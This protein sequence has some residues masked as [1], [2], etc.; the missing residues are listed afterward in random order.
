MRVPVHF[1]YL[2]F[3]SQSA[4]YAHWFVFTTQDI[5]D[6]FVFIRDGKNEVYYSQ[7]ISYNQRS[8][9]IPVEGALIRAIQDGGLEICAQAKNSHEISRKWY[10]NQCKTVPSD[11]ARW[12]K[13]LNLDKR[14][15]NKKTRKYKSN[16]VLGLVS[17]SILI[18]LCIFLGVCL[19]RLSEFE[20]WFIII[21][22]IFM[23]T[24][25]FTL[26]CLAVTHPIDDRADLTVLVYER[27]VYE[28]FP[29]HRSDFKIWSNY[30][31]IEMRQF[32][33]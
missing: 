7:T 2:F 3:S 24:D 13:K 23:F 17:D 28:V 30:D 21:R 22:C 19:R 20:L 33:V 27:R 11:Y 15:L 6:F 1:V 16:S 4:I 26:P 12:P 32:S 8:I 31:R 29:L 9:T 14:R 5:A 10:E 25:T 18:T